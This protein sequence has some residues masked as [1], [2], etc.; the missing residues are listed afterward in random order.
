MAM[1]WRRGVAVAA[2]MLCQGCA[3]Q[4]LGAPLTP[5]PDGTIVMVNG[6]LAGISAANLTRCGGVI[7][8]RRLDDP[9]LPGD[10]WV[11]EVP[12]GCYRLVA[13]AGTEIF[14]SQPFDLPPSGAYRVVVRTAL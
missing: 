10:R 1:T 9:V 8:T 6:S 4:N 13:R 11:V 14:T 2:L 7:P 3:E 12:G 5:L